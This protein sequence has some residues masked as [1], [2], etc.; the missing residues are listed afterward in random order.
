MSF[1][2]Y[3]WFVKRP[4]TKIAIF[5]RR[6][7]VLFSNLLGDCED[8][9][10]ESPV[11]WFPQINPAE[12]RAGQFPKNIPQP[13]FMLYISLMRFAHNLNLRFVW[14]WLLDTSNASWIEYQTMPLSISLRDLAVYNMK[15]HSTLLFSS[16][17]S[18]LP[19][20]YY[21]YQFFI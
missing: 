2:L 15:L 14:W 18:I 20:S 4:D 7:L 13:Y 11:S 10:P 21:T 8:T 9:R 16:Q 17:I 5:R 3:I 1:F 19:Y 12:L 6:L